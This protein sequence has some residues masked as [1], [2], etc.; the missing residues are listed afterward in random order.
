MKPQPDHPWSAALASFRSANP[1]PDHPWSAALASFR[2]AN[3]QTDLP[4]SAD[5]A[6][7]L[8]ANPL[9]LMLGWVALGV[10]VALLFGLMAAAGR[11]ERR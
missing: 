4:W 7:I 8:S 3:P 6:S 5:L 1:Q 2:S 9:L 10:V 11:R